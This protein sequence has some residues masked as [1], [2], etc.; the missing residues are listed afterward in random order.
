MWCDHW[1]PAQRKPHR[2]TV[3]L[4]SFITRPGGGQ[5]SEP[6]RELVIR[7]WT[8]AVL[9]GLAVG[10]TAR[11][12]AEDADGRPLEDAV[13]VDPGATCLQADGLVDHIASWL[14]TDFIDSS[15]TIDVRGSPHFARAVRF[16]VQR[17]GESVAE[18][19][20]E[21]GP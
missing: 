14:G 7:P 3:S 12:Q 5:M 4:A 16:E 11:V 2:F 9:A 18:R 15:L 19:R 13:R 20:F 1:L 8:C 21:P 10:V 6:L 17:G